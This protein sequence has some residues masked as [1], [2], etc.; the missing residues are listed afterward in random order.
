[1]IHRR[2]TCWLQSKDHWKLRSTLRTVPSCGLHCTAVS[3]GEFKHSVITF[4][5]TSSSVSCLLIIK[6]SFL[7][8]M[9]TLCKAPRISVCAKANRGIKCLSWEGEQ[10][11][12]RKKIERNRR[13]QRHVTGRLS[14]CFMSL[15]SFLTLF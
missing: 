2:G 6:S 14:S 15:L 13:G 7:G 1:M 4:Q 9:N 12:G 3:P 8:G 10:E 11:R 5:H